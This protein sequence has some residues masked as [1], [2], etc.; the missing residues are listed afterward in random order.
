MITTAD[1]APTRTTAQYQSRKVAVEASFRFH[2]HPGVDCFTECCRELE[3]SLSPYDVIRL[4]QALG[5][6]SHAFLERYA[7]IEFGPD[8]HYPKVYLA[9]IDDGRASC[10]FVEV[11]GCSVYHDRPGACRSYPLGRGVS[12]DEHGHKSEQFIV[13]H[14]EHCHGFGE[15]QTQT[16]HDWQN[17][18][19]LTE[20]NRFN[21]LLLPLLPRDQAQAFQR[22]LQDEA[23]RYVDTLYNL[24]LFKTSFKLSSPDAAALPDDDPALLRYAIDW[25]QQQWQSAP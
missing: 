17:D 14:E 21:D 10:P 24:E 20:Y 2:C 5:L 11:L 1:Q 7:I 18:Q 3:L 15:D 25:L 8:D 19:Q 13:T 22:L 23:T 12:L 4:K 9:M 16:V 6:S